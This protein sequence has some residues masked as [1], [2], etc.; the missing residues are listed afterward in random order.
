MSKIPL[1]VEQQAE[2]NNIIAEIL[3]WV[4]YTDGKIYNKD[5][6]P[7]IDYDQQLITQDKR[8]MKIR[9]SH[10]F[11]IF[12]P[13]VNAN[14]R[15]IVENALDYLEINISRTQDKRYVG[16]VY[17]GGNR[18]TEVWS[19]WAAIS[20]LFALI[21][22]YKKGDKIKDLLEY[23]VINGTIARSGNSHS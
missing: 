17:Y 2:L 9:K 15:L 18:V 1:C 21:Y 5:H 8:S 6:R 22:T 12:N 13:I 4:I 10:D 16:R 20:F 11:V 23:E 7:V 14:H 19:E 3:G